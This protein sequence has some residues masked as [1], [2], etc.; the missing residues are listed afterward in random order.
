MAEEVF[1]HYTS[2]KAAYMIVYEGKIDAIYGEGVY[3]TTLEPRL[4]EETIKNNN[5]DDI[6][7]YFEIQMP[8]SRVKRANDTRDIQV[9]KGSLQL[10]DYTWKLKNWD[11]ELLATQFFMVSSEGQSKLS[12]PTSM[13][14]YNL[15]NDIVMYYDVGGNQVRSFVYKNDAGSKYLY[16]DSC[17]VWC[18][19]PI[20]GD[21]YCNLSQLRESTRFCRSPPKTLPWGYCDY[22]VFVVDKALKVFPCYF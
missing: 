12:Q 1:F 14:R 11:G 18:I 2:I 13:G 4:G 8:I 16:M 20:A 19:G 10:S 15:V 17:G 7:A 22:G 21:R 3:L 5:W 6:E 9:Y